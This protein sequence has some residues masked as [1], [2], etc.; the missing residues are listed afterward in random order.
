MIF[1]YARISTKDQSLDL[2]MDALEKHGVEL[3]NI[4]T[5]V[6]SGVREKRKGLDDLLSKL[7]EGDKIIVWKLDRIARSVIH[8]AK[9]IEEFEAIGVEFKS[10]QE[11]FLD[12]SSSHG[13]FVYTL[14]SAVAQLERDLIRERTRAGLDAAAKRGRKGGRR[15]GLS[16]EAEKKAIVVEKL[17]LENK[18]SVNDIMEV[19]DIKSKPTFYSYLRHRGVNIGTYKKRK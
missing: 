8:L 12:T 17:Y 11:P 14:F 19:V 6:A 18:M 1:G 15:P 5:D 7:R 4:Y 3:K 2:Q 10:V 9:L 16:K 13:R